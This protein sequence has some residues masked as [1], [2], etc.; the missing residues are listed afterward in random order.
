MQS[1]LTIVCDDGGGEADGGG[2]GGGGVGGGIGGGDG[3]A[4]G[5]G[6]DVFMMAV[7]HASRSAQVLGEDS[8]VNTPDASWVRQHLRMF[9]FALPVVNSNSSGH[10][11]WFGAFAFANITRSHVGGGGGV[12]GD[13]GGGDGETDGGGIGGGGVGGVG[14]GG[15]GVGGGSVGGVGDGGGG[16]VGGGVV[17]G[18]GDG[19]G[20]GVFGEGGSDGDG[21]GL[22]SSLQF[23]V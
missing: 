20:G 21:H 5:G 7:Q 14:D 6:G 11:H 18:I 10:V 23:V 12:G 17:G 2:I 1:S 19:G 22:H 4:D 13:I 16:G 3:E 9:S 15:G 8:G